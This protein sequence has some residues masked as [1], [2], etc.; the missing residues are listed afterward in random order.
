VELDEI[1]FTLSTSPLEFLIARHVFFVYYLV[2]F[3]P[4]ISAISVVKAKFPSVP[5]NK[6]KGIRLIAI[7]PLDEVVDRLLKGRV[8]I[9]FRGL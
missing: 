7:H 6:A 8:L 4:N 2:F 9:A 3:R 5:K 1:L